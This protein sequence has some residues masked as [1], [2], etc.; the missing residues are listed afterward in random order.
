MTIASELPPLGIA[1]VGFSARLPGAPTAEAFWQMLVEGRSG[2]RDFSADEIETSGDLAR[3]PRFVSHGYV[4]DDIDRFDA[5]FFDIPPREAAL[6]DPQ[7]RLFLECAWAALE[8]AG[9]AAGSTAQVTGVFAGCNFNTYLFNVAHEATMA[10]PSEFVDIILGNDKDYL[11]TRVSYKLDLKGPSLVVQ[12]A[13]ST[14][15]TAVATAAQALLAGQC[16]MAL[17]GAASVRA[18]QRT[19]YLA[20]DDS[21]LSVDGKI[22][23]FSADATGMVEGNGVAAVVLKRV[24]DAIADRDTIYAV[25][26]GFAVNNDG[27]QKAGFVAPSISGQASV[28]AEALAMASVPADT[29]G[30]VEAHGTGT[31]IGDPIEITA[32]TQA[33]GPRPVG[34]PRCDIGSVKTNIGHLNT[35]AGVAGLLKATLALHHETIPPSLH[36]TAPNSQIDF[37]TAPFDVVHRLQSWSRGEAPRRA[38]VSSFGLGGTNVHLV[39]EEAP[40]PAERVAVAPAPHLLTFSARSAAALD[41][42]MAQMAKALDV[43]SPP[44]LADVAYTLNVGRK[45]MEHRASVVARTPAEAVSALRVSAVRRKR[46]T[47][48]AP[49]HKHGVTFVFPGAGL[50]HPGMGAG[51]YREA[52]A[53]RDAFDRCAERFRHLLGIALTD[54]LEEEPEGSLTERLSGPC[55]GLPALFAVDYALATLL[56]DWG[57]NPEAL[58]GHS[59]GEYV[60]ATVSGVFSLDAATAIIAARSALIEKTARGAMLLLPVAEHEATKRLGP[61]LAIAAITGP[62]S[63]VVSGAQQA[64]DDLARQ[65]DAEGRAFTRLPADRAGHSPLLDPIIAEFRN[66]VAQWPLH[67]PRIPIVSNLTGS[68]LTPSEATDP[69]YWTAHLRNTVRLSDGIALLAEHPH[70]LFLEVGPGRGLTTVLRRHPAVGTERVVVPTMRPPSRAGDDF[71]IFSDSVGQLWQ[72]GVNL[73]LARGP[74]REQACRRVPLP[75][76]PFEGTRHWIDR[77]AATPPPAVESLN[78]ANDPKGWF[79]A[80][81]WTRMPTLASQAQ[82]GG[83]VLVLEGEAPI[84]A[85]LARRLEASGRHV[86]VAPADSDAQALLA[87]LSGEQITPGLI[88]HLGN[89]DAVPQGADAEAVYAFHKARAYESLVSLARTLGADHPARQF[90]ILVAARGICS[91]T[92][93]EQLVP[94]RALLLGPCRVL[95]IEMPQIDCGVVEFALGSSDQEVAQ[96]LALEAGC[97][98]EERPAVIAVRRGRRWR[99]DFVPIETRTADPVVRDGGTYLVI[100]GLGGIGT[101]LARH[102]AT[103]ARIRLIVTGRSAGGADDASSTHGEALAVLR[104]LGADVC[105]IAAD[106]GDAA[107]MRRVFEIADTRFGG[108]NGIIHAAGVP[109]GGLLQAGVPEG[110]ASNLGPKVRGLAIL[111]NLCRGRSLDFLILCSSLGA[112]TGAVGQVDNTAANAVLDAYAQSGGPPGCRRCLTID[113]DIWLDVGM[114]VELGARH[115][116]IAG[117][118]LAGMTPAQ[119][120]CAFDR[121]VSVAEPQVAVSLRPLPALLA[122]ARRHRGEA[123]ARFERAETITP[124]GARPDLATSFTPPR[125]DLDHCLAEIMELRLGITGVGIDDDFV[126]L[127]GDSLLAMP[128]AAQIRQEF[129]LPF[130]VATLLR[131]RTVRGIADHLVDRDPT[132]GRLMALAAAL[133]QVKAMA[134]DEIRS[135]L[136]ATN[137]EFS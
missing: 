114:I 44:D 14:S 73:D 98:A 99:Q 95:P 26:R 9:Y 62:E 125:H 19:G 122:E 59:S 28:I 55:E 38:A 45:P 67:A 68:W 107:D 109:G 117:H 126:E 53:Y 18:Q 96:A 50:Q 127:G 32:L 90:R 116:K 1:I 137:G 33:Y 91:V 123:I 81:S 132:P 80:P 131:V 106:A 72:A 129:G 94:L 133:R 21:G 119:G 4:L 70:R 13:C 17:A 100:G 101:Q 25:I 35:A 34:T 79:F 43:A 60:A 64:I 130:P 22:R 42:Q 39:L 15:L 88:I 30:Y 92:G 124:H 97:T 52:P 57:I 135:A 105:V 77:T 49:G 5:A 111:D 47:A 36:F 7:H 8:H 37:A 110:P 12:T 29:I 23:A 71:A 102:L 61:G 3:D 16:D 24:A 40:R 10:R 11:A 2:G 31:P 54:F 108:I 83:V 51:L 87:H 104:E 86:V 65:L 113:W 63:C 128:L 20:H 27:V 69:D 74:Y 85:E 136:A 89:L 66:A 134:P 82:V 56:Q 115:E 41:R 46:S 76:Y 75:T 93:D 121:A 48:V 112:F 84:G 78:A 58:I 103:Q 6:M 118:A 120:R